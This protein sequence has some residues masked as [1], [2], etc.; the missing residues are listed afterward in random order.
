MGSKSESLVNEL[1]IANL[2]SALQLAN[3]TDKKDLKTS[4]ILGYVIQT[5][6]SNLQLDIALVMPEK[7]ENSEPRF[8]YNFR[9]DPGK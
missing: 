5:E 6:I 7:G 1:R 8:T 4:Q 3:S 2:L 9:P